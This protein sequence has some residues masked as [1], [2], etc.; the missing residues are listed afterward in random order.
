M[1]ITSILNTGLSALLANQTALRTTASNISNA[2]TPGYV[3]RTVD[4]E[5]IGGGSLLGGVGIASIDRAV[6]KFLTSERLN[7]ASD[8]AG[9]DVADR[10]LDQLQASMGGIADGRDP[11]SRW[12]EVSAQLTSVANDPSSAIKRTQLLQA[13]GDFT[14]GVQTLSDQVQSL[15]TQADSEIGQTV[16]RIN[17]LIDQ[18]SDL[19]VPLQR[20]VLSGDKATPLLDQRDA[21]IRELSSL[22]E[23]RVEETASG[24][25]NVTTPSGFALITQSTS[26]VR[27]VEIGGIGPGSVFPSITVVRR[28]P[29]TGAQIGATTALEPH[30]SGGKLKALLD[31]R[32]ETL[33]AIA[34]EVGALAAGA[35]EA[36]NAAHNASTSVPPP[37]SLTGR[38]TGLLA[39][40]SLGFTGAS[41]FAVV[42]STG[43]LVRRVDV[44]FSAGTLSIDGGAATAFTQT[45]GG[46]TAALNTALGGSG[47]ASFNNGVLSLSAAGGNGIAIQ[48]D[49]TNP[50]DRAGRGFSH[51][52]GLNDLMVAAAPS[53]YA[54][55]LSS[56]DAH[57]FTAGQQLEFSVRAPD[58]SVSQT[59]SYT[60]GGTTIGDVV[61]GLNAAAGGAGSFALDSEGRLAFTAANGG[62]LQVT[63][64]TTQRGGTSQSLS[65]LFGLGQGA[66]A[67][68]ASGFAV[69][70]SLAQNP[71]GLALAQLDLTSTT[72]VG[73]LVLAS[74]DSKGA[75]ALL[76]AASSAS[77]SAA[78]SLNARVTSIQDFASGLV[79]GLGQRSAAAT[80]AAADAQAMADTIEQR[81]AA[82][83]GVNLDEELAAMM[84]Y[85][86]A[87]NAGARV[88]TTAQSLYDTLLS[89]MK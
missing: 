22:M 85:Q 20:A 55:G 70:S 88:M 69:R 26:E 1:S 89:I 28:D 12:A 86:Q 17:E 46:F 59:F 42:S 45:V 25:V 80:S 10:F 23:V 41:T 81:A 73:T 32:D 36:L 15:R 13:L 2:N 39:S 56:S 6:D 7:T 54:T 79:V 48:Q 78:G 8:A 61:S 29:Q 4:F 60:V 34:D 14:Q 62:S 51:A 65:K 18:I 5:T 33:P 64:D 72:T 31:M 35:A 57:G 49:P 82:S 19:N 3:R 66:Q 52:F 9:A 84:M 74:A 87:Y 77:F 27:H 24:R 58:G 71:T 50:S 43:A 68:Q 11:A 47:S 76:G 63:R 38:D 40:D 16:S 53:S 75:E 67:L 30:L 83:E 44:D 37:T 21:A